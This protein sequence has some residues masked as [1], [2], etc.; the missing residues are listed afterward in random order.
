[1]RSVQ[2]RVDIYYVRLK[3]LKS[4]TKQKLFVAKPAEL[5]RLKN[6]LAYNEVTGGKVRDYTE[7]I[8]GA[9]SH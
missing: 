2:G 7:E 8:E 1:M 3:L 5:H 4:R 9:N 6:I